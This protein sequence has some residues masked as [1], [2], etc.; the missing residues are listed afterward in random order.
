MTTELLLLGMSSELA[1]NRVIIK[2]V[3]ASFYVKPLIHDSVIMTSVCC[4]R[5]AHSVRCQVTVDGKLCL[6]FSWIRFLPI[7]V[8]LINLIINFFCSFIIADIRCVV[9]TPFLRT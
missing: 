9:V 7:E 1:A 2:D 8:G 5:S 6:K 4:K 3:S